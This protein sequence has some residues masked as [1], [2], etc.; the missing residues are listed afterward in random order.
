MSSNGNVSLFAKP[1]CLG[2]LEH[3]AREAARQTSIK[4]N[5]TMTYVHSNNNDKSFDASSDSCSASSAL[6]DAGPHVT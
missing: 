3:A 5:A 2:H 4:N 1:T 6:A